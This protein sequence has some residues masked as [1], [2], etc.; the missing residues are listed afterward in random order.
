MDE[1]TQGTSGDEIEFPVED[2]TYNLLQ[3]L[4]SKLESLDAYRTYL[5]DADEDSAQLFRQMAQQDSKDATRLLELLRER[6]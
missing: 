4:T 1:S 5:E 6:L 3:T 2:Q